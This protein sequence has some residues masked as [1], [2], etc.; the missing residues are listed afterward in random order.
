MLVVTDIDNVLCDL[1]TPLRARFGVPLDRYPA[2]VPEGFFS[3]PEGMGMFR[4]ARPFP[5]AALS[6]WGA[7]SAGL[8]VAYVSSRPPEARFVTRRWLGEN[9]FPPSPV[10]CAGTARDKVSFVAARKGEVLAAAEDDPVLAVELAGLG[11]PVLLV[12]W[13]YNRHVSHP[14]IRRVMS[15]PGALPRRGCPL[16]RRC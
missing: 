12:D 1:N 11:V 8:R 16:A 5:G 3:S 15:L 4:E 2:E 9:G 10:V 13:P 7:V 6:L 14:L